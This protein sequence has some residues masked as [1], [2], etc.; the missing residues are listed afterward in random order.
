MEAFINRDTIQNSLKNPF[1]I[2]TEKRKRNFATQKTETSNS[3]PCGYIEKHFILLLMK[4]NICYLACI[5]LRRPLVIW[6][7][8][9]TAIIRLR[10]DFWGGN[11]PKLFHVGGKYYFNMYSPGWPSKA[12]NNI[13]KSELRRHAP[14]N[15]GDEKPFFAFLAITR[16]CPMKC[17]HCFEWDNL[18]QKESFTKEELLKVIDMYQQEGV[19]QFHFSG[20]EPM[21]RLKVLLE[22]LRFSKEKSQCWVVTSGFNCTEE[23]ARLLKEAGCKGVM[24][25]IDHHIPEMHNIF[26]GH[27]D[28]FDHATNAVRAVKKAGM[29][30]A[31]CVC[32]TKSFID[33]GHLLPYFEF[34]KN[35]GV[36]FVQ[37]LEP[38]SVGHY[39]GK[40]VTLEENHIQILED[41]FKK[42]NHSKKYKEY[43]TLLYHG[44]HQRRIG[45]LAGS[46][47]VYI[48]SAGDVHSCPFCHTSSFN[49][50]ELIRKGNRTIPK[51]ENVCPQFNK[52]A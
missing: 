12:Y 1:I 20:G 26:R 40:N 49:I 8:Y 35:L 52:I 51:K 16:K 11:I 32:A 34:A 27:S 48:D 50:I 4:I 2:V 9:N 33:G 36:H 44:Y 42:V 38:K 37:L 5:T 15:M 6:R 45:C 41:F 18:N 10:K 46:R 21:T 30:C 25:S 47:S 19:Q 7:T 43:P 31:I 3:N 13:W 24:V 14:G 39:E 28:S 17:E 23:N 22:L 29:V